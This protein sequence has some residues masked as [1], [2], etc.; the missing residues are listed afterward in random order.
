MRKLVITRQAA[1]SFSSIAEYISDNFS[2][3]AA[4][5]YRNGLKKQLELIHANPQWYPKIW[6]Q[7]KQYS[8]SVYFSRTIILFVYSR[9]EV[10][11]KIITD[12]RTNWNPLT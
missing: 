1:H 7:G 6:I 3:N 9:K 2:D 12:S 5:T 8:R 4:Q 10:V 11:I